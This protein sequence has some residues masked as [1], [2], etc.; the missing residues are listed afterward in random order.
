MFWVLGGLILLLVVFFIFIVL[1]LVKIQCDETSLSIYES[2]LRKVT[3]K[4]DSLLSQAG[5]HNLYVKTVY[6]DTIYLEKQEEV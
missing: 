2:E 6:S 5:E 4:Y 3:C 1:L